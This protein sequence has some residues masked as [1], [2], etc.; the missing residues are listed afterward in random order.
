MSVLA[1]AEVSAFGA[2]GG[3]RTRI[4]GLGSRC[5]ATELHPHASMITLPFYLFFPELS[6]DKNGNC[7]SFSHKLHYETNAD[8]PAVLF[9]SQLCAGSAVPSRSAA[10]GAAEVFRDPRLRA[11][12]KRLRRGR[13][14]YGRL[15]VRSEPSRRRTRRARARGSRLLRAAYANRTRRACRHKARRYG[16]AR[17]DPFDRGRGLHRFN[18]YEQVFRPPCE[19]P[20]VLF[21]GGRRGRKGPRPMRDGRAFRRARNRR[22]PCKSGQQLRYAHPCRRFR[23][24]RM[25]VFKQRRR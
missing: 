14:R 19:G 18:P 24:G 2:G 6:T 25:R 22:A 10:S 13:R 16:R 12:R 9:L 21:S 5:S 23:S 7:P 15:R 1:E 3:N 20:D 17:R 4:A 11:R 8:A